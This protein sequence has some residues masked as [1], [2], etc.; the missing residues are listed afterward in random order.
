MKR[1]AAKEEPSQEGGAPPVAGRAAK[2]ARQLALA[3]EPVLPAI[4]SSIAGN[5]LSSVLSTHLRAARREAEA[6]GR[7]LPT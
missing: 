6:W 5:T 2:S 7:G 4:A 3:V 1:V